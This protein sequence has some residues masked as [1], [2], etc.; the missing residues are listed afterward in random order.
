MSEATVDVAAAV[1][2]RD[3]G[4]EFLLA[5]RPAGKVYEGYWEFPGGKLEA[6]EAHVY[7]TPLVVNKA[8]GRKF[9]KS[10]DGAIWLDERKTSVY[11]FYHF[12][13]LKDYF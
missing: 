4:R 2:L 12:Q 7:S 8:T 9:G 10:E 1:I 6:G 13:V 3:E 11:K 5:R